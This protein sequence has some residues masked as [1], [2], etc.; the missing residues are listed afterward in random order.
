[1]LVLVFSAFVAAPALAFLPEADACQ[2][3]S[4]YCPVDGRYH[5]ACT[6]QLP[7]PGVSCALTVLDP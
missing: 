4:Y 2:P 7:P 5:Y 1:M 3:Y 6:G